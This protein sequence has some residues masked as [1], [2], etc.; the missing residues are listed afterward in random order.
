MEQA[1]ASPAEARAN[2]YVFDAD[3][4]ITASRSNLTAEQTIFARSDMPDGISL[5]ECTAQ[6]P[7][8][9]ILGLSGRK[10]T[11]SEG[12]A[13]R[14]VAGARAGAIRTIGSLQLTPSGS[15]H[16]A[17]A[18]PA[19]SPACNLHPSGSCYLAQAPSAPWPRRTRSRS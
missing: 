13:A 8:E 6:V 16:L 19:P 15:C 4:L 3:G 5:E 9:L 17:Q 18:P 2:F 14:G 12:A 11:I 10:G 1:G 7:P